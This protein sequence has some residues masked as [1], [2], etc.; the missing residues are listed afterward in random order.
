[1]NSCYCD[2]V[3]ITNVLSFLNMLAASFEVDL[4]NHSCIYTFMPRPDP[5]LVSHLVSFPWWLL[6]FRVGF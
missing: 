6:L 4:K 2:A 5:L 1:M 3:N